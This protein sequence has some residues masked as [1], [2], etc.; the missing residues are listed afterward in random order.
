MIKKK[1]T[2]TLT[3]NHKTTTKIMTPLIYQKKKTNNKRTKWRPR[4]R[5]PFIYSKSKTKAKH[6]ESHL[7]RDHVKLGRRHVKQCQPY[8]NKQTITRQQWNEEKARLAA[9]LAEEAVNKTT[10]VIANFVL[11]HRLNVPLC[12]VIMFTNPRNNQLL[13]FISSTPT[14]TSSHTHQPSI[15]VDIS[16]APAD[17]ALSGIDSS[18]WTPPPSPSHIPF[19]SFVFWSTSSSIS[20][21]FPLNFIF[22]I[23]I[24]TF[25]Y[26]THYRHVHTSTQTAMKSFFVFII[27]LF[28]VY[29]FV[30]GKITLEIWIWLVISIDRDT[31]KTHKNTQNVRNV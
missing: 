26:S 7:G 14:Q 10:R 28:F 13:T 25:S 15:L 31:D 27:V 12:F 17:S 24:N 1:N 18:F 30:V 23:L 8:S 16:S 19:S 3:S 11:K 9:T 29:N 2:Q 6:T 4:V 22:F 21:L 5:A 20:F